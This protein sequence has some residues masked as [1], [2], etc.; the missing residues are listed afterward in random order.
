VH[1]GVPV[2]EDAADFDGKAVVDIVIVRFR[3]VPVSLHPADARAVITQRDDHEAAPA[4]RAIE[5]D[6][7]VL[8]RIDPPAVVLDG[9]HHVTLPAHVRA[10]DRGRVTR[11]AR[12][13]T[14]TQVLVA[15]LRGAV[16]FRRSERTAQTM[17]R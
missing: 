10:N 4:A 13:R 7:S 5:E 11:A 12:H 14:I 9:E 17:S 6:R 8:G 3:F 16:R 15:R 1:I 2:A